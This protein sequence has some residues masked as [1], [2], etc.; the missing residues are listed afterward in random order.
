MDYVKWKISEKDMV[1]FIKNWQDCEI[2]LDRLI[3]SQ[4]ISNEKLLKDLKVIQGNGTIAG[5]FTRS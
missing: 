1:S 3:I 5:R 4:K 2:E